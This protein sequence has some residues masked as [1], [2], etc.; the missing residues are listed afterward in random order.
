MDVGP[1]QSDGESGKTPKD[2][3]I[4][5]SPSQMVRSREI[6]DPDSGVGEAVDDGGVLA[7]VLESG[8]E[9]AL[10]EQEATWSVQLN[11]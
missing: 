11:M 10:L 8:A 2:A 6:G 4:A 9:L 7:A 3:A 1:P 5:I